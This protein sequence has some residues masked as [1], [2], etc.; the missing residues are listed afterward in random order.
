MGRPI[1][2]GHK[3]KHGKRSP[4]Y[5]SWQS[6]RDRCRRL[7]HKNAGRYVLRGI[8]VCERWSSFEN[9]L[10]DMGERPEGMTLDRIDCD[11]DYCPENCRWATW[12]EQ[13]AN[14]D[15]RKDNASDIDL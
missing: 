3:P 12:E 10:A 2:H 15:K 4:T 8:K 14:R 7:D 6:M 1:V 11:K 13:I 5:S 9:F